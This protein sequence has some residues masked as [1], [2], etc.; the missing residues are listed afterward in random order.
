VVQV[1]ATDID[2]RAIDQARAGSYPASIATDISIERLARFF[3]LMPDG[4]SYRI[5]KSIRDM[6]V[7]SE[8]SVIKD[9]PFSRL[10]MIS[11][12]NMLIYMGRE[13]Q[14]K[15]IPLFHYALNPSGLLFLGSSESVGDFEN[16]FATVDRKWKLYQ[17]IEDVSGM[18]HMGMGKFFPPSVEGPIAR[19]VSGKSPGDTAVRLRELTERTL[20]QQYAPASVVI[21]ERGDILYIHGRT[22]RYLEPAQGEAGVNILQMARE[23]LR[24]ELT[25]AIRKIAVQKGP[26][27]CPG[28][29]VRTNGDFSTVNM[30]VQLVLGTSGDIAAPGLVLVTFEEVPPEDKDQSGKT[31]DDG[32]PAV[33]AD[34][35]VTALEQELRAKEE[36]LQTT[37]EEMETSAEELKSTN[38]EM[39]SVNEELQSTNEELETSKEELESVNEELATVNAELQGKVSDLSRINNDMNNLIAGTG[40][41]TIFVDH[42]L[43]I[44]RFTP[45]ATLAINLIPGDMGR[46]VSHVAT[47]LEGYDRLTEDARVVLDTLIPREIE[48]ITKTGVWYLMRIAPYRTLENVI[49]GLVII[50]IDITGRKRAE[51]ERRLSE[52]RMW[53]VLK[54]TGVTVFNQDMELRYTWVANPVPGFTV[55]QML[56]KTDKDLLPAEAAASLTAI[57]RQALE[58]GVGIR[59]E[60]R[61]TIDGVERFINLTVEPH[62]DTAGNIVGITCSSMDITERKRMSA[63]MRESGGDISKA[64]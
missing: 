7:F 28:L 62:R 54:D 23:G 42:Q 16:L 46:P 4:A 26:V 30:T 55:E 57:K 8:Q 59:K 64:P 45:S 58:S 14:K 3:T 1:F 41:G 2:G 43:R 5:Q 60:A 29:R 44:R 37:F 9:P 25:T 24:R 21:N 31:A 50:F 61:M 35:R 10:D 27:R 38:E 18:R 51:E 6:L 49:E 40:F 19:R 52:E 36:Y 53:I 20:L 32:A 34:T 48:V 47:N 13:L 12:R 39:Q 15:L 22:G 56:G 33:D 11:C 17:R 63:L